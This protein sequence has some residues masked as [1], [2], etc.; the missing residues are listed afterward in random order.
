MAQLWPLPFLIYLNAVDTAGVNRWVIYAITTLL[1]CYPNG[2]SPMPFRS[3]IHPWRELT[4]HNSASDPSWVE[5]SQLEHCPVP[6]SV[7][8]LL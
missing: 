8:G 5:L 7:C 3:L 1:L 2:E 4:A 6:H